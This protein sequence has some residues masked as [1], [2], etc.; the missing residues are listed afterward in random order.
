MVDYEEQALITGVKM[1]QHCTICQVPPQERENLDGSWPLRTHQSTKTQISRQQRGDIPDNDT[2]WVHPVKNFA[3]SHHL[4]NIHETMMIDIL[5]QLL[6]GTVTYLVR[7]LAELIEESIVVSRKKKGVRYDV[8]SA[9]GAIQLDQRFRSIPLFTGMKTFQNYSSIKQ[10]TGADRRAIVRQ[11]VPVVAPLLSHHAPAAVH[12]ARAL[13]DFVVLAQ[14]TSHDEDTLRYLQHAL[15]RINKLK[16]IF[17]HLRP[18]DSDTNTGHFNIPK[19]HV[20]TH[21]AQHIRRYGSADNVDTEH[22]EAAHKFLV[23]DFFDRT[24]KRESFQQQLLLHNTRHLNII[25]MEDIVWWKGTRGSSIKKDTMT[26]FATQASRAYPLKRFVGLPTQSERQQVERTGLNAKQWCSASTLTAAL[27]IP[28]LLDALA[29]FVR[30]CRKAVDGISITD[31]DLDRRAKD[32]SEI[33]SYHVSVHGSLKCWKRDGKDV[34]DLEGL[35]SERV[36]CSPNWQNRA[37]TWRRDCVLVQERPNENTGSMNMLN[38]RL[39]GQLQIN[40]SVAD[41]LRQDHRGKPIQY[42]GALVDLYKPLNQGHPHAVHGM[43]EMRK[44]PEHASKSPQSI[45]GRRFYTLSTILQSVHVVPASIGKARTGKG[46]AIYYINNFSDWDSY[47]S[48]YDED[49]LVKGTKVALNDSRG[50]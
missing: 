48:I 13:V 45:G 24:N 2:A 34:H 8:S 42:T 17:R 36:Y 33:G 22:S 1:N 46:G 27:N 21:Y 29:V 5:H 10:W 15:F 28:G 7:W 4:V 11:I 23:K 14:Y 20:M 25:A 30:D 6:K 49:F 39:A 18:I 16:D 35:I 47:N 9:P 44:W 43:I 37:G 41:P 38:G 19:L 32:L 50:R 3:W 31:N 40:L 26:A 12:Y